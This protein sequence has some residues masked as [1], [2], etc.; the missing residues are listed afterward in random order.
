ME[1]TVWCHKCMVGLSIREKAGTERF[2][3]FK[4]IYTEYSGVLRRDHYGGPALLGHIVLFLWC[5]SETSRSL[6]EAGHR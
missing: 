5:I 2:V 3:C 6:S 4:R 1:T